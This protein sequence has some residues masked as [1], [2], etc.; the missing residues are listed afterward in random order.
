[1]INFIEMIQREFQTGNSQPLY[2]SELVEALSVVS[3]IKSFLKIAAPA[4]AVAGAALSSSIKEAAMLVNQTESRADLI[5]KLERL[6]VGYAPPVTLEQLSRSELVELR[7]G[8]RPIRTRNLSRITSAAMMNE[9]D[10]FISDYKNKYPEPVGYA[11]IK[12]K[13]ASDI[14]KLKRLEEKIRASQ[15]N[16]NVSETAQLAQPIPKKNPKKLPI[17]KPKGRKK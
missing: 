5:S 11:S 14:S 3:S 2:E 17:S 9:L 1:M 13:L 10:Q 12:S 6:K 7:T 8:G 4:D 16:G 15:S